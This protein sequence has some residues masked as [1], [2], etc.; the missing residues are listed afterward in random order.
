VQTKRFS[1]K[2]I[3]KINKPKKKITQ[4]FDSNDFLGGENFP[5]NSPP[6][7]LVEIGVFEAF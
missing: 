4:M 7:K 6:P 5:N 3:C 2:I 1:K